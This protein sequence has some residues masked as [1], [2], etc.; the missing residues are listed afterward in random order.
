MFIR[1]RALLSLLAVP[2]VLVAPSAVRAQDTPPTVAVR[3]RS[4]DTVVDSIKLLSKIAGKEDA[5]Q[6][7]EG[8]IKAQLGDKGLAGVDKNRPLGLY[9]RLGK[10]I[11]DI[12]GAVLLPISDPNA[13][14][15]M[16]ENLNVKLEKAPGDLY[17]LKIG[18]PVESIYLRFAN[19]YAYV[20]AINPAALDAKNLLD[21]AKV[22]AGKPASIF[23]LT[24]RLDQIPGAGKLFALAFIEQKLQEVQDEKIPGETAAQ[25][26]FRLAAQKEVMKVI[27]NVVRDAAAVTADVELDD[28][29]GTLAASFS[30][31]GED[32]SELSRGIA[33]LAK[34]PSLFGG[35][36]RKDAA[37]NALAH[38]RIPDSMLQ[39]F[40]KVITEGTTQA[41]EAIQ[42]PA[43]KKQADALFKALA[44]TF[45]AGELDGAFVLQGPRN[46]KFT[47]L[48][49]GKVKDGDKLGKTLHDL[50]SEALKDI[51]PAQ[52][53]KI[54]LDA[55]SVGNVKIHH[56]EVPELLKDKTMSQ[57]VG[58]PNLYVAF[59]ADA[60]FVALG[61]DGMNAVKTALA[62]P[63][64]PSSPLFLYEVDIA[65]LA[66]VFAPPEQ[67]EQ[68]KK[69]FPKEGDATLRIRLEGGTTLT[70]RFETRLAVLEFLSQVREHRAE[71]R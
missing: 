1:H 26:A 43:K 67:Q 58:D 2:L 64:T 32:K 15:G 25:K 42:D 50:V 7:I 61:S 55:A 8:L 14:L 21:P 11:D 37:F 28:K 69:L 33:E 19:K 23:S 29:T 27:S 34:S 63:A 45:R 41:L 70:F 35:V 53:D 4:V 47:L 54:R 59:R 62:A 20:T 12:S 57:L 56:L 40:D 38:V 17:T 65:R 66:A 36:L 48:V 60:V 22:L 6:Q 52:R 68:A 3:I 31:A 30:L 46:G 24:V 51:P 9:I 39:A 71:K 18:P 16:L 13:F 5:A 10:E 44:P 49:A